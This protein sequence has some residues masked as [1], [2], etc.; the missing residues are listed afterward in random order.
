M[1]SVRM[2]AIFRTIDMEDL[3]VTLTVPVGNPQEIFNKTIGTS[4]PHVGDTETEGRQV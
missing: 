1:V 4:P 3:T 2:G